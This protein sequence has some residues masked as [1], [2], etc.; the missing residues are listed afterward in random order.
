MGEEIRSSCHLEDGYVVPRFPG[1]GLDHFHHLC[2]QSRSR[3]TAR[4]MA[5]ANHRPVRL[6]RRSGMTHCEGPV[7]D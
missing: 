7:A 3:R 5:R 4:R 2:H 6:E 1:Q